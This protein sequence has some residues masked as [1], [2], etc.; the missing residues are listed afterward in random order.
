MNPARA[1]SRAVTRNP[2][3]CA[4]AMCSGVLPDALR[5]FSKG[6]QSRHRVYISFCIS[7]V[8]PTFVTLQAKAKKCKAEL[9]GQREDFGEMARIF[10]TASA[11]VNAFSADWNCLSM[12]NLCKMVHSSNTQQ[13]FPSAF[14]RNSSCA[15][16]SWRIFAGVRLDPPPPQIHKYSC[17]CHHPFSPWIHMDPPTPTPTPQIKNS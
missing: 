1:S 15:F 12:R 16:M 13:A 17:W 6:S 8:L 5:W 3:P 9:P 14:F 4:A 7:G 11:S 2:L 10:A